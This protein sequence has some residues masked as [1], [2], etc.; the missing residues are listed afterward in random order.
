MWITGGEIENYSANTIFYM[1]DTMGGQSGSPVYTWHGG[2]W[3]V[4]GVHS[5][6][7]CPNSAP[8]FTRQMISRFAVV[9]KGQLEPNDIPLSAFPLM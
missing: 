7:G 1:N 5:Y 3:T 9:L 4:V 2:Y 6:G 8:R